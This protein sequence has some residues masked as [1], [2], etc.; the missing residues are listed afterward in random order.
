MAKY[1][2]TATGTTNYYLEVEANSEAEALSQVQYNSSDNWISD[3]YE[4]DIG[5]AELVE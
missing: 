1:V 2:V 4:F 5:Y 3:G